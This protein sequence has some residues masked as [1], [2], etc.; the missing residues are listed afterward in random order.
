MTTMYGQMRSE[1]AAEERAACRQI[2]KEIGNYGVTQRQAMF[3]IYLLALELENVEHMRS[4]T[5]LVKDAGGDELFLVERDG[6]EIEGGSDG[7]IDV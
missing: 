4:I 5:A 7:K 2:V 3:I 6:A 1:K